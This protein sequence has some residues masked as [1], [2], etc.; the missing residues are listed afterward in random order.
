[1]AGAEHQGAEFDHGSLA[2]AWLRRLH[3][4][5]HT[6]LRKVL[7][8]HAGDL[9]RCAGQR[10]FGLRRLAGEVQVGRGGP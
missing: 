1:M 2:G 3:L 9:A 7:V 8:Q 6:G 4:S 10:A 5:E